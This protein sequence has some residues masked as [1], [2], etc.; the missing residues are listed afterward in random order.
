[1]ER[2]RARIVRQEVGLQGEGK[3]NKGSEARVGGVVHSIRKLVAGGVRGPLAGQLGAL[4]HQP[5]SVSQIK[6][7]V[8]V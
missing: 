6:S 7:T 2:A 4:T 1:M 3:A 8:G 5:S